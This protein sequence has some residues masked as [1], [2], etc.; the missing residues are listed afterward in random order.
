MAAAPA[1]LIIQ[2]AFIGDVVL[3]TALAEKL[4]HHQPEASIDFLLRKGNEDLLNGHPFLRNVIV[5]DKKKGKL[6]NL[7]KLIRQV[8]AT[9]YDYVI[10]VH[11]FASSGLITALSG[12]RVTVGFDKNPLSRFF[13]ESKKHTLAKGVHEVQRNQTLIAEITD[14]HPAKPRLYPSQADQETIL[15]HRQ[16]GERAISY[17]CIAPASVWFT[18]QFPMEKWIAFIDQLDPGQNRVYLLGAS[19]DKEYAEG[20]RSATKHS[21]VVNLSGTL[22]FLESAALMQHAVMNFVNDSAPLHLASSVNA[23]ITAVFCST[24]SDF[25]F[26]PLSDRSFIVETTEPL[27]CR[28]C[29]LHGYKACPQGHFKCALTITNE[30]LLTSFRS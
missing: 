20:I 5:W 12:A 13:T 10:N 14:E 22:S 8:R 6:K 7:F 19:S 3:A 15:K 1:F 11:R 28:P 2:T 30:Q 21:G 18:K 24:V 4:H 9:R 26:G 29:G 16:R 17:I 27:T 23:P 25:G